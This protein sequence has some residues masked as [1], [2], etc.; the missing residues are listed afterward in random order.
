MTENTITGGTTMNQITKK[1]LSALLFAVILLATVGGMIGPAKSAKA[2]TNRYRVCEDILNK[3]TQITNGFTN[4]SRDISQG[5][6]KLS[7][8]GWVLSDETIAA[9]NFTFVG[10]GFSRSNLT[11]FQATDRVSFDSGLAQLRKSTG[12]GKK[13]KTQNTGYSGT[14]QIGKLTPGSYTFVLTAT[15]VNGTSFTVLKISFKIIGTN[16]N[17]TTTSKFLYCI[18]EPANSTGPTNK[19]STI[20]LRTPIE[21]SLKLK[22]WCVCDEGVKEYQVVVNGNTLTVPGCTRPDSAAI[23]KAANSQGVGKNDNKATHG[24]EYSLD[25]SKLEKGKTYTAVINA[26]T[27]NNKTIRLV[28]IQFQTK[29]ASGQSSNTT[30]NNTVTFKGSGGTYVADTGKVPNSVTSDKTTVKYSFTP[31]TSDKSSTMA[32]KDMPV[33]YRKGYTFLGFS[34]KQNDTTPKYKVPNGNE[35]LKWTGTKELYAVWKEGTKLETPYILY[36]SNGGEFTEYPEREI[37][38]YPASAVRVTLKPPKTERYGHEFM[39]YA[40]V[41]QRTGIYSKNGDKVEIMSFFD[42]LDLA[43]TN[44]ELRTQTDIKYYKEN[45][46][47]DLSELKEFGNQIIL[48]AVWR[49]YDVDVTEN[50]IKKDPFN[51][52]D[53]VYSG[54][55]ITGQTFTEITPKTYFKS[56]INVDTATEVKNTRSKLNTSFN[57]TNIEA[58]SHAL[59]DELGFK[60]NYPAVEFQDYAKVGDGIT[61]AS[62]DHQ[63]NILYIY[64]ETI[65]QNNYEKKIAQVV[66]HE[67]FHAYQYKMSKST[68]SITNSEDKVKY[69]YEYNMQSTLYGDINNHYASNM[70]DG[71]YLNQYTEAEAWRFQELF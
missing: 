54:R 41:P 22:A 59:L 51:F 18:D 70:T 1:I 26:V 48:Y 16:N 52:R 11:D 3:S 32:S 30:V 36:D 38:P 19:A 5:S 25:I 14:L 37:Q 60:D 35:N 2:A 71:Y 64:E 33:F 29:A 12:I 45:D 40:L 47:V 6:P 8:G 17:T 69:I 7:F 39:G 21:K 27:K 43:F 15:T 50:G 34:D 31:G 49:I 28:G 63:Y 42:D 67:T 62:Y 23:I 10:T 66:A 57:K 46:E 13:A 20:M 53:D 61:Y 44:G 56:L 65:K 55:A 4:V 58:F 24:L 68:K 9:Y